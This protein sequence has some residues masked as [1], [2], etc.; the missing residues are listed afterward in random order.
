ML[1]GNTSSGSQQS[2]GL[3][4]CNGRRMIIREMS[5]NNNY[6][7]LTGTCKCHDV[8][9]PRRDLAPIDSNLPSIMGS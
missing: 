3:Q 8:F 7:I 6:Y 4:L 5:D 1:M 2:S 9:I